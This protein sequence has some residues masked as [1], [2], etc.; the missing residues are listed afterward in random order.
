MARRGSYAKGV[1]KR[2]E[3]LDAALEVI[4]REGFRKTSVREIATAANLSQTGLLHHFASK[5]ELFTEILRR[6]DE[7]DAVN[8][9]TDPEARFIDTF[10][11]IIRHNSKV[12]GLVQL[13]VSLATEAPDPEHPAHK[14]FTER[15]EGFR[16]ELVAEIQEGQRSG[17]FNTRL[18]PELA[19]NSLLALADGLQTQWLLTPT[20]DM[21]AHIEAA[22]ESWRSDP[23]P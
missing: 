17:E 14:F 11:M 15:F 8:A 5:N 3:I 20:L 6:R 9:S 4:A 22:I 19:A 1:A 13:Y 21:A 16:E 23:K 12:P 18:N 2:E 10:P 7:V